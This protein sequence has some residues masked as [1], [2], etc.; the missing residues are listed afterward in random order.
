MPPKQKPCNEYVKCAGSGVLKIGKQ[1]ATPTY[2]G[3]APR[4]TIGT[5][6]AAGIRRPASHSGRYRA[7]CTPQ[8]K[9]G[10]SQWHTDQVH[11]VI[12]VLAGPHPGVQMSVEPN[13]LPQESMEAAQSQVSRSPGLRALQTPPGV[14]VSRS[15]QQRG[16]RHLPLAIPGSWQGFVICTLRPDAT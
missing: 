5:T 13:S 2:S 7:M 15:P 8:A 4:V 9:V 16:G 11:S 14:Q 12:Q 6:R 1:T 3:A 10:A